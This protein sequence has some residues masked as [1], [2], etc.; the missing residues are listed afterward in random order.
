MNTNLSGIIVRPSEGN[1]IPRLP[2]D[3]YRTFMTNFQRALPIDVED[4]LRPFLKLYSKNLIIAGGFCTNMLL[5]KLDF[6]DIDLFFHSMPWA[7]KEITERVLIVEPTPPAP[8]EPVVT[9][10]EEEGDD[11]FFSDDDDAFG[12]P[13]STS[14]SRPEPVPRRAPEPLYE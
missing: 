1:I 13:L 9:D 3:I 5:G 2:T 4:F 11:D 12:A 8:E 6:D 7:M 14:R 10:L